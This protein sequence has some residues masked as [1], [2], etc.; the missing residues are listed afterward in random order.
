MNLSLGS[1]SGTNQNLDSDLKTADVQ[2]TSPSLTSISK[3][4]TNKFEFDIPFIITLSIIVVLAITFNLKQ[5]EQLN[6]RLQS[7]VS[8]NDELKEKL[9]LSEYK[10]AKLG[11]K[12]HLQWFQ[13]LISNQKF[14]EMKLEKEETK[15]RFESCALNNQNRNVRAVE[16]FD[17]FKEEVIRKLMKRD[18]DIRSLKAKLEYSES[19]LFKVEIYLKLQSCQNFLVNCENDL[20]QI[21]QASRS[22]IKR[23]NEKLELC[24]S[25]HAKM[26]E[27]LTLQIQTSNQKYEKMKL[28]KEEA[29]AHLESALL[30]KNETEENLRIFHNDIA[31]AIEEMNQ[32]YEK[33]K[34]EKEE[35]NAHLQSALL[36]KNETKESLRICANAIEEMKQQNYLKLQSFQEARENDLKQIEQ[37]KQSVVSENEKAKEKLKS[38]FKYVKMGEDFQLKE[39]DERMLEK[40]NEIKKLKMRLQILY[41]FIAFQEKLHSISHFTLSLKGKL[42]ILLIVFLLIF[43]LCKKYFHQ[44]RNSSI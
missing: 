29:N 7:V 43:K 27:N 25:K 14:E 39:I 20:K 1:G 31:N 32:E 11:E 30:K 5:I 15:D 8:E 42:A 33:M 28:E 24:E 17:R 10:Y 19:N 35:A 6:T 23:A 34:L 16:K 37:L 44:R 18:N 26:A 36:Q 12:L 40:D 13:C 38:E 41:F 2:R 9:E 3:G 4:S 22:E 21:E